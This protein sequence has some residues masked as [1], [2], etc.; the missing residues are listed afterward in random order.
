MG[1]LGFRERLLERAVIALVAKTFERT[2]HE[3]ALKVERDEACHLR[4]QTAEGFG[5]GLCFRRIAARR[6]DHVLV[7]KFDRRVRNTLDAARVVNGQLKQRLQWESAAEDVEP[8]ACH[9]GIGAG[10]TFLA[11]YPN[12][13]DQPCRAGRRNQRFGN[14]SFGG[15]FTSRERSLADRLLNECSEQCIGRAF[16]RIG[17]GLLIFKEAPDLREREAVG[18][19]LANAAQLL[20]VRLSVDGNPSLTA[21]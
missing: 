2:V 9:F 13:F 11:V 14:L 12:G 5:N 10:E 7:E 8:C 16:A 20:E 17:D 18:K 15:E 19:E 6:F 21:R 4:E 1:G 3:R